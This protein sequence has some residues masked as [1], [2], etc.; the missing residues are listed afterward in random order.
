[1]GADSPRKTSIFA[2][3]WRHHQIPTHKRERGSVVLSASR[4]A[5]RPV[6][7]HN[8]TDTAFARRIF[9]SELTKVVLPT[10]GPP[11]ITSTLLT[12][13]RLSAAR[14]LAARD[15]SSFFST[16]AM[17]RSA[18][19]VDH[20]ALRAG[21]HVLCEKPIASNAPEAER[22]FQAAQETGLFLGEAF[23]YRY[24]P[25]AERVRTLIHDGTIGR[26]THLEALFAV[27]IPPTN[28]RWDWSLAGGA[29][30]DLGCYPLHMLHEFSGI[31][32]SG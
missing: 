12:S 17:A 27:P 30:M 2:I 14:W 11:V 4:F 32:G 3:S 24:H 20:R 19:M 31:G 8:A 23:H 28:I 10:P 13:A 16:H 29:T 22:M 18:S 25:L 26:L 21:K 5:A 1:M 15:T 6:G 7:A 9:S